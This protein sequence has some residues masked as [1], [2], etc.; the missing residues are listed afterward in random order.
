MQCRIVSDQLGKE[1]TRFDD[2][3]VGPA[4]FVVEGAEVGRDVA[5]VGAG[6]TV[7]GEGNTS[8][9]LNYD[10]TLNED[11]IAH[12]ATIGVLIYW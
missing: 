12:T 6:W 4:A 8:V 3:T 2:V 9:S 10:A 1:R 11:L 7:I 5:V